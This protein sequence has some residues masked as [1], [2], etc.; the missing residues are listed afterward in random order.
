MEPLL[1]GAAAEALG[2][3]SVNKDADVL[4]STT[5]VD[6]EVNQVFMSKYPSIFQGVGKKKNYQVKY[7]IDPTVPPV[8]SPKRTIPYHLEPQFD[9]EVEIMEKAGVIEDHEGPA[10]WI[11][12]PVLVP[13]P[14][15]GLRFTI[16]MR[17]PNKAILDTGLPIPKPEDIRKE[18]VGCKFFTKMDFK[19]AFHQ[20]EL[21]EE[22]RVLTVFPHK[23]KLKRHTRLSMGTKPASG[24]LNKALRPLFSGIP[25]AHIVHDDLVVAT[26]TE[27]E[28]FAALDRVL[29]VIAEAN[30]TLNPGKCDFMKKSIHFWGMIISGEGV[31]PDPS[32]VQALREATRPE[33]KAELIC[34]FC[35]CCN[36]TP[37][38]FPNSLRKQRNFGN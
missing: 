10:P 1:S 3:I 13:K 15:G 23:G 29:Q 28:H 11:S 14:D 17:E 19:T 9:K 34:R 37:N 31:T 35:A 4:R 32:K 22:S 33:N 36:P 30:L 25:E 18:F 27:D 7:H 26:A 16:D 38:L 24:E 20:L 21:D 12:N 2:I 8:A 5:V 6:D